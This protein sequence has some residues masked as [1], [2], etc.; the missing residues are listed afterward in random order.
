ME[1]Q[2]AP[3]HEAALSDV[4]RLIVQFSERTGN[5][6]PDL[7]DTARPKLA[8]FASDILDHMIVT[9][10]RLNLTQFVSQARQRFEERTEHALRD[11]EIGFIQGRSAVM[12]ES[13]TNQTKALH[14]LRAIY[15]VTRGRTEPVFIEEMKTGLSVEDAKAAWRY[16]RDRGLIDTFNIPYTARINGTGVDAIEGARTHPDEPSPNFPL[17]TYN[18]V[19]NTMNVGTMSNSPVQQAGAHSAQNQTYN[20]ESTADLGRLVNEIAT[21]I[22]ELRMDVRQRQR[23]DAQIATLRAQLTAEPDPVIVKQAGSTLWNITESAIGS[24]LASAVQPTVWTSISEMMRKL[25]A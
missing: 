18:I 14:L 8:S 7:C 9:A 3:I 4:M 20:V 19:N 17:V 13:S 10:N 11:I 5:A 15:D 1:R 12:T 25:F 22:D 24:L 21:R 16:L 23:A 2:I 6:I